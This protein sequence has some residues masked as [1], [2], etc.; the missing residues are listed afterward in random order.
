M[1]FFSSERFI[2][3]YCGIC[4]ICNLYREEMY[5]EDVSLPFISQAV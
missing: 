3:Y 2:C 4:Y 5:I 1:D